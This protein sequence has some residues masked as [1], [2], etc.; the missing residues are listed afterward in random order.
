MTPAQQR[1]E[2]FDTAAAGLSAG[3]IETWRQEEPTL[4][5]EFAKDCHAFSAYWRRCRAS[6]RTAAAAAAAQ[7]TTQRAAA[8]RIQEAARAARVRF[9]RTHVDTVYDRL[10]AGRSRFVRLEHLVVQAADVVP[11][12][13]PSAHQIEA[14]AGRLQ[15]EKSG[16]EI[17]QG[18]FLSAVLGSE[19]SGRHLCHAMLLPLPEAQELLPQVSE[20]RADRTAGRVRP[21]RRQ[22]RDR[23]AEASAFSQ[24]RG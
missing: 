22:S 18:L 12:L 2:T 15:G 4:S 24:R 23:D 9:L 3:E 19:R 7:R 17:D 10:T 21:S 16:L 20:G 11:G 8:G 6:A 14:E 1:H 5:G 13:V